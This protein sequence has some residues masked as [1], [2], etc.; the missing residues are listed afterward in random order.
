MTA[1]LKPWRTW[2]RPLMINV[3]LMLLLVVIAAVG[4]VVDDRV[5]LGEPVWVKPLKFG[6]AFTLYS[7]ALA[8]LLTKLRR[9]PRLGWWTGTVFAFAATLEVAGITV[10]A[11]RGTFSHFNANFA[12]PVT[13]AM[14]QLFTYG[15]AAIFLAQLVIA[16]V[17]LAQRSLSRPL[18]RAI[19][20]G[21]SLATLG[22]LVPVWWMVTN[23]HERT[24]TDA[25]G[26][27]ITMYQ[28]HGVGDLDGHGMFLTD[29][30]T[31]GG[32]F[33]VPHFVGLHAI[34]ILLLTAFVLGRLAHRIP[35][36]RDETVQARLMIVAG[37]AYAGLFAVLVWQT[38]RGQS[39]IHPD[40]A[41]LL[42]F[43]GVA[44]V[45]VAGTALVL[46]RRSPAAP[47]Q[48]LVEQAARG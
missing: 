38:G 11:A 6:L 29:W 32:D 5:L 23:A 7:G 28:G 8:W 14:T 34:H 26:T 40:G 2:H 17:V 24:V 13:V 3:S 36:L 30:S 39:L 16:G 35:A 18:T 33:R 15:V 21:I 10:Q 46:G 20:Y 9:A 41:T 37:L 4:I 12:D 43:G 42:G 27:K 25:N 45:A 47:R 44:A 22:M 31:T 1:F 48:V 19:R